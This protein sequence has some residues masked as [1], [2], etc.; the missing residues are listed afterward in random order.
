M[1]RFSVH[2]Y[3][4]HGVPPSSIK[5]DPCHAPCLAKALC[6]NREKLCPARQG[7]QVVL[8]PLKD[9]GGAVKDDALQIET[10]LTDDM[11]GAGCWV[12]I[13]KC[14]ASKSICM[15]RPHR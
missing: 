3:T 8:G 13:M 6:R 2:V 12:D 7:G 9:I 11:P 14:A 15:L 1:V 10:W 5:Q 4:N